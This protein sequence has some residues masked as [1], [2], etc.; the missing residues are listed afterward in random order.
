M[1][2]KHGQKVIA[3]LQKSY[4]L[5]F[6]NHNNNSCMGPRQGLNVKKYK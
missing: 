4:P 1:Q 6:T 5:I 3:K 2:V